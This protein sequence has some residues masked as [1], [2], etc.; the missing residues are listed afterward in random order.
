M[1]LIYL[2]ILLP[3]V[4]I[5]GWAV[6]TKLKKQ[7]F[8]EAFLVGSPGVIVLLN[9]FILHARLF[10]T[11][12]SW[13]HWVQL[14]LTSLI[15]PLAYIYFSRQM[16]RR[17]NNETNVMHLGL[18][19]L[20]LLPNCVIPLSDK[21]PASDFAL[22]EFSIQVVDENKELFYIYTGDLIMLMQSLLTMLRMVPMTR[23]L[24]QN[25]LKFNKRMYAFGLWWILAIIF[26]ITVALGNIEFYATPLGSTYYFGTLSGLVV[27]IYLL[28]ALNLD[29][30]PIRTEEGEAV[31]DLNA[32]VSQRQ[33]AHL[34]LIRQI[35]EV[36]KAYLQVGYRTEDMVKALNSER[37]YLSHL[38]K[39][40][41]GKTFSQYINEHRLAHAEKL[42]LT[43]DLTLTEIANQSGFGDAGYMS[44]I[45][46]IV[47][48][49]TPRQWQKNNMTQE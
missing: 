6:Y 24:R 28:L 13:V 18:M 44:R 32:Y 31:E 35:V 37:P 34:A 11:V 4:P 17:F 30:N 48:N 5:I 40:Y 2:I 45:F 9:A 19:L 46:K 10:S 33:S 42:L 39:E 16:G 12:S 29:L 41:F 38:M 7:N 21:L 36:D 3:T 26:I 15:V 49:I 14:L 47:Y 22:R 27:S 43:T 8:L 1:N 20:L 25:H 23:T